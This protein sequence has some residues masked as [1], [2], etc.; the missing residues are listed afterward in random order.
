[1]HQ[2]ELSTYYSGKDLQSDDT[3][4]WIGY[5]Q[6]LAKEYPKNFAGCL[7]TLHNAQVKLRKVL[8]M[9]GECLVRESTNKSFEEFISTGCSF[10]KVID[11]LR[12]SIPVSD[13]S[14]ED[15]GEDFV[16]LCPFSRYQKTMS[17]KKS[18][19]SKKFLLAL[20]ETENKQGHIDERAY[21][22]RDIMATKFSDEK[23]SQFCESR[24]V[25]KMDALSHEQ[26]MNKTYFAIDMMVLAKYGQINHKWL[27]CFISGY[28]NLVP[29]KSFE[30]LNL[31]SM[32]FPYWAARNKTFAIRLSVIYSDLLFN[33]DEK[34]IKSLSTSQLKA[35]E[36]LCIGENCN[37]FSVCVG[38]LAKKY[39][40]CDRSGLELQDADVV[41]YSKGSIVCNCSFLAFSKQKR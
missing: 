30:Q 19:C 10:S 2:H 41:N 27:E 22:H 37:Q 12:T 38:Y 17:C 5:F 34:W 7:S 3:V 29:V 14:T 20:V 40:H 31:A 4:T 13:Y 35:L 21:K 18:R 16:Y 8:Q 25:N 26:A 15:Y 33:A 28:N 36:G 1:M 39:S 24:H 6:F 11:D 32:G 23:Y 9:F